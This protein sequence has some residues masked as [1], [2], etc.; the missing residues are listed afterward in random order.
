MASNNLNKLI[1]NVLRLTDYLS[2]LYNVRIPNNRSSSP[3]LRESHKSIIAKAEKLIP[4]LNNETNPLTDMQKVEKTINF[5]NQRCSF[6][7]ENNNKT[8]FWYSVLDDVNMDNNNPNTPSNGK[9]NILS[10]LNNSKKFNFWSEEV[11]D[12][13]LLLYKRV[14]KMPDNSNYTDE[15]KNEINEIWNKAMKIYELKKQF[16][17]SRPMTWRFVNNIYMEVPLNNENIHWDH[18]VRNVVFTNKDILA[19]TDKEQSIIKK[20]Q[21]HWKE[22]G[23]N[24]FKFALELEFAY[25]TNKYDEIC[26]ECAE[27]GLFDFNRI[28]LGT[29]CSLHPGLNYSSA[30]WTTAP[31]SYDEIHKTLIELGK[32]LRKYNCKFGS[33][34]NAGGHIHIDR[35]DVQ[36]TLNLMSSI[37][38]EQE[39]IP[40][41]FGRGTWSSEDNTYSDGY[42]ANLRQSDYDRLKKFDINKLS[43]DLDS[44]C[45]SINDDLS[46]KV[47]THFNKEKTKEYWMQNPENL[48]SFIYTKEFKITG[49]SKY[50]TFNFDHKNTIEI[51]SFSSDP[52]PE[53]NAEKLAIKLAE[54]IPLEQ[55]FGENGKNK[56]EELK[57]HYDS[58]W[59]FIPEE[60]RVVK[61]EID[62][63]LK[64]EA[65]LNSLREIGYSEE[66]LRE[67]SINHNATVSENIEN[68]INQ[69][70]NNTETELNTQTDLEQN[71]SD[72][73]SR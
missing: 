28:S 1:L 34:I 30:E 57:T 11:G 29:D 42:N 15:L 4:E 48:G 23:E 68:F 54:V 73:R 6:Y 7:R 41:F 61:N 16:L 37:T 71:E 72:E 55:L 69:N 36:K 52:F 43:L 44:D 63:K 3:Y 67:C 10:I 12:L 53:R 9:K 45:K 70:I 47:K 32:V 18:F 25:P 39:K 19:F 64:E 66:N 58:D 38:D 26:N 31:M 65:V 62:E 17:P 50:I 21:N 13:F 14:D 40:S 35:F 46:I 8:L 49:S 33:E 60:N 5:L 24:R 51:R 20:Y 59:H 22:L 27:K 2:Y 56:L